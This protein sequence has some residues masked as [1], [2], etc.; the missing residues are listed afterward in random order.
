[1]INNDYADPVTLDAQ[2]IVELAKWFKD[3][4]TITADELPISASLPFGGVEYPWQSEEA[5]ALVSGV[6][7]ESF[8]AK[9]AEILG[10]DTMGEKYADVIIEFKEMSHPYEASRTGIEA[11]ISGLLAAWS[12]RQERTIVER[13]GGAKARKNTRHWEGEP[14]TKALDAIYVVNP[15]QWADDLVDDLGDLM[16]AI[17]EKEAMKAA[18]QLQRAGVI[19]RLIE[20]GQGFPGGRTALDRLVGGRGQNRQALLARITSLVD[21]MIRESALRQSQKVADL[22]SEMDRNGATI[23]EIKKEVRKLIGSRSS[24]RRGLATAAA[25]SVME[26]ARNAVYDQGGRYVKR[27]WRTM[28]DEKVRPSHRK[29]FGQTRSPGKPFRVGSSSMM[30]PGDLSAPVEE[31]ANC[32]CWIE[33]QIRDVN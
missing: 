16:R 26:G 29:A 13:I 15:E 10:A 19:D 33:L 18:R 12:R 5:W 9:I 3:G 32:R 25:T 20:G 8:L 31:T 23:D 27:V 22:I 17:A 2:W 4:A 21:D 30:Y 28:R 14:G 6:N 11:E 1:M 7:R 24:W